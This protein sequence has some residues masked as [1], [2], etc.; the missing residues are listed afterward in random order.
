ML[1]G[2]R[3]FSGR[4]GERRVAPNANIRLAY[5]RRDRNSK[6]PSAATTTIPI[7]KETSER[8]SC[9]LLIGSALRSMRGGAV[10]CTTSA[11]RFTGA[12]PNVGSAFS[13]TDVGVT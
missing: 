3:T 4:G 5:V 8:G 10:T 13:M 1:K 7:A 12:V 2:G 9:D 11:E 6:M